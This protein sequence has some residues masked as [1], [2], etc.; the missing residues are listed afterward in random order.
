LNYRTTARDQQGELCPGRE[1]NSRL[2]DRMDAVI[3]H[4]Q[5]EARGTPHEEVVERAPDTTLP[6]GDNARR[7]LR[8][9]A[10][11][12]KRQGGR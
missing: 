8:T 4:E 12:V 9:I 10:E 6:I 1:E 5:E 11:G 3:A 2:R 7:I